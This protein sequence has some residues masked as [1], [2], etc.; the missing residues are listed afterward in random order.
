MVET[1]IGRF[2]SFKIGEEEIQNAQL[3]FADIPISVDMLL[4]ADFFLSH[5]IMLSNSQHQ[6]YIT[7]GGGPV[8]DLRTRPPAQGA[9]AQSATHEE[10]PRD[11]AEYAQRGMGYAARDMLD[12]ALADFDRACK[13]AP[14]NVAYKLTRGEVRWRAHQ[15]DPA[16]EDFEQVLKAQPANVEALLAHASVKASARDFVAAGLDLDRLDLLLP[17]A[18]EQRIDLARLNT[19]ARRPASSL[20]Q[21]DQWIPLHPDDRNLPGALNGR[22]WARALLERNPDSD[23]L[24]DALKDCNSALRSQPDSSQILDSRGLVYLRKGKWD[25][26]IEDYNTALAKQ[27][28]LAWSLYG[29]GIARIRKGLSADG[30]ADIAAATAID[31][32]IAEDAGYYGIAP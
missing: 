16:L 11:A 21:F 17:S 10:E 18:S 1:W 15:V 28:K 22:C 25:R 32:H 5:R 3:R 23:L 24:D 29:R 27:P 19:S 14:D 7:Y 26:A 4:G 2:S 6:I 30:Q 13:L 8:F 12:R 31:A 9:I 20:S